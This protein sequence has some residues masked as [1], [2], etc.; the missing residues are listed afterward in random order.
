M[1]QKG[2]AV[3]ALD[4]KHTHDVDDGGAA[5]GAVVVASLAHRGESGCGMLAGAYPQLVGAHV[6][7]AHVTAAEKD[8]IGC[9]Q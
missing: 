8:R 3:R 7:H 6:A 9:K 5:H 1:K 4:W 2:T